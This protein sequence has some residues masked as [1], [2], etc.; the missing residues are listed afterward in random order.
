MEPTIETT[1]QASVPETSFAAPKPPRK[2][3]EKKADPITSPEAP[4]TL[5][6]ESPVPLLRSDATPVNVEEGSQPT[7]P[8]KQCLW[9]AHRKRIGAAYPDLS[10]VEQLILAKKTYI[11]TSG[12]LRSAQSLHR[13]AF[14]LRNPNHNLTPTQLAAAIR[15]D[16]VARI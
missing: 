16:L 8:K 3:K 2:R 7:T 12:K 5:T 14:L 13:E 1:L 11:P 6:L 10:A 4:P 15:M 9:P